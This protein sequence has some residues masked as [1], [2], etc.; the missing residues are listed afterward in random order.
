MKSTV[1]RI[2]A[3]LTAL[4]L[5]AALSSCGGS[6]DSSSGGKK[7]LTLWMYPV[8]ADKAANDTYWKKVETDFEAAN[9]GIDL[10]I[11]QQPWTD[12]DQ[13]LAAAF[14]GKKGPDVLPM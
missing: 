11:E 2:A 6:D 1:R 5:A 13:K 8:I 4:V 9:S 14:S 10:K 7:S 12:R 3:P